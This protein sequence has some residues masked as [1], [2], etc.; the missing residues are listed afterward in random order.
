MINKIAFYD[1]FLERNF[2]P[3]DLKIH[4]VDILTELKEALNV[5]GEMGI[6]S[7]WTYVL[8]FKF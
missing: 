3:E 8:S 7:N 1:V 4:E 6:R 5:H 2:I